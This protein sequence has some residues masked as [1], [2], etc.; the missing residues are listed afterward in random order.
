MRTASPDHR[1]VIIAPVRISI[2]GAIRHKAS[3][4]PKCYEVSPPF[5]CFVFPLLGFGFPDPELSQELG[6]L[7]FQPL[8]FGAQFFDTLEHSLEFTAFG[9]ELFVLGHFHL[10]SEFT[11][12]FKHLVEKF[13]FVV[14]SFLFLPSMCILWWSDLALALDIP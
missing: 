9:D 3:H 5:L 12:C 4:L 10:D 13:F 11:D 6:L 14:S 8:V 7:V 1:L 2:S